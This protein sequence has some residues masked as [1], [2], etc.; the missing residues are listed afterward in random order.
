MIDDILEHKNSMRDVRVVYDVNAKL[1]LNEHVEA[2]SEKNAWFHHT[3][4]DIFQRSF[5]LH[6]PIRTTRLLEATSNMQA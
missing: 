1:T 2:S 6:E 3:S 4:R 5:Y